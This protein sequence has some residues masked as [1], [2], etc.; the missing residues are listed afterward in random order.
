MKNVKLLIG[1]TPRLCCIIQSESSEHMG[2]GCEDPLAR[3][4]SSM[5]DATS[6]KDLTVEVDQFEQS[7]DPESLTGIKLML[8]AARMETEKIK[9]EADQLR[10][11][12]T[13]LNYSSKKKVQF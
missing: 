2:E 9:D 8:E 13:Y 11:A 12:L 10:R 4:L 3:S 7:I 1:G 6:E 5:S